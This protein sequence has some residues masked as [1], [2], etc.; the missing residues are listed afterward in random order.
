MPEGE[1]HMNEAMGKLPAMFKKGGF[2]S[3]WAYRHLMPIAILGSSLLAAILVFLIQARASAQF[4]ERVREENHLRL[5]STLEHVQD[6]FNAVYST[7]LFISQDDNVRALRKGSEEFIQRLY[8]HQWEQHRLAEVYV[9][10][11]DFPGMRRPFRTFEHASGGGTLEQIHSLPRELEEYQ[12]QMGQI[13]RFVADTN[14]PAMLSSEIHLCVND[15]EGRRARGFVYSVPIHSPDGLAGIVAGMIPSHIVERVLKRDQFQQVNLLLN[16]RGELYG[17]QQSEQTARAW[18]EARF[19]QS[20]AARFFS[21]ASDSF[22]VEHWIALWTPV[23]VVSAE[24]WWLVSLSDERGYVEGNFLLGRF[25]RTALPGALILAGAALGAAARTSA[26]RLEE[27]V[28]HL[29]ER[30]QLEHQVQAVSDREQ[31]RIG[32]DLHEDLCQ[33]LAGLEAAGRALIKRLETRAPT[34]SVLATQIVGELR[35]TLD[36]ARQLADELQPVSLLE[37][38]FLAAIDK[39]VARARHRF[40]IGCSIENSG[41]PHL[42]DAALATQLYRV[43]QEALANALQHAQATQVE[44]RLAANP[45]QLSITIADD[46]K[47]WPELA[48]QG[49]GMGLRIMRYRCDLIGA[50]L[51]INPGPGGGTLVTCRLPRRDSKHLGL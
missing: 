34:E 6:Y 47:G 3:L 10:E 28:R 45:Q 38:G 26:R 49:P 50:V 13:R 12:V 5:Y 16:E 2:S 1:W 39:L 32:E 8:D 30:E 48:A 23:R 46:G 9:V 24:K 41:F 31:R 15:P 51:D 14:Q 33:R 7:L 35:E 40:G 18:F 44:I 20:G 17:A 29:R 11:R 22:P 4:S 27:Q 19:A 25:G 42:E 36:R 43:T 37:E 21:Q